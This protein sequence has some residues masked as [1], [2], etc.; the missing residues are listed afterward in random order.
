MYLRKISNIKNYFDRIK[1]IEI[2]NLGI[3]KY[4][5]PRVYRCYLKSFL[6]KKKVL[7]VR[8]NALEQI[9]LAFAP[10]DLGIL[11]KIKNKIKKIKFKKCWMKLLYRY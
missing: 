2:L 10:I 1:L 4:F 11:N 9:G 6:P 3:L 7:K 8:I 5:V